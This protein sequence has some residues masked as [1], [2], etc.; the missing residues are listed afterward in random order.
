MSN[1]LGTN[2]VAILQRVLVRLTLSTLEG[3]WSLRILS[4]TA[5][6]LEDA[7]KQIYEE[8]GLKAKN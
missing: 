6:T 8:R 2:P 5:K 7:C 1:P 4:T 3:H